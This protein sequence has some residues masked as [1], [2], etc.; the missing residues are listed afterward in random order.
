MN[1]TLRAHPLQAY[2]RL[3]AAAVQTEALSAAL[4]LGVFEALRGLAT[5]DELAAELGLNARNTAHLL[6]LLWGMGL[7]ERAARP[8]LD[9]IGGA[10]RTYGL[11]ETTRTYFLASSPSWAGDTWHYR[12]ARLRQAAGLLEAQVRQGPQAEREDAAGQWSTAARRQLAQDQRAATVPAAVEIVSRLPEFAAATRLLDLGGGP[13]WVAIELA[14]QR[15]GLAGVVFDL[16]EVAAVAAENIAAAGLADRL[17]V[18]G[19]D[20]A[21]DGVGDGYDLV[22]CSSV[23]H[24]VPDAEAVLRRIMAALRP[25][26]AL[27]CAHAEIG[28]EPDAAAEV[29]QFYLPMLMQGRHV[30]HRGDMAATLRRLGFGRIDGFA[31]ALFPLAPLQVVVGR[32]EA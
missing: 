5:P 13:G 3:A 32:K 14:R 24:F 19:G 23:L 12:A 22:W 18:I 6:E 1:D 8:A 26:G 25:G 28:D 10:E 9:R 16:P 17:S 4:A 30:G 20:L 21:V 29:L 15:D 11:T 2:W 31:C 27:V 7:L